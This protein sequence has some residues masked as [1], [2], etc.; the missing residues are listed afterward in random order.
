MYVCEREKEIRRA[1]VCE[2][3]CICERE[4]ERLSVYMYVSVR[5]YVCERD[6]DGACAYV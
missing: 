5:V 6:R 3:A 4:R 2:R 1:C